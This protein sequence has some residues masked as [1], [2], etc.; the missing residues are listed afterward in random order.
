VEGG[1]IGTER[2]S[3]T[4][5]YIKKL[6]SYLST[7]SS[8][9][10]T[11]K[12]Y[13]WPIIRLADLY[14]LYAEALNESLEAPEQ[15][16]YDYVNKVRERAGLKSIEESWSQ[17]SMYP[18]KYK[19]KEGMRKIIRQERNIELAFEGH[20]FWDIRRWGM[21]VEYFKQPVQGWNI[22]GTTSQDFYQPV[23]LANLNYSLRDV[24]W[25]VAESEILI[26]PN[27]IQN[28]GW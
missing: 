6:S 13:N 28:P 3:V 22:Y 5:Y 1:M 10:F 20:R 12:K 2:Y 18:E 27:F 17:Y 25:P 21:A 24:F 19:N 26:N 16:V 15:E 23:I 7:Y 14:L 9:T 11:E 8:T 4:G